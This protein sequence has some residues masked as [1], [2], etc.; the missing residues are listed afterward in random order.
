MLSNK[1]ELCFPSEIFMVKKIIKEIFT[2]LN[3]NIPNIREEDKYDLRLIFSELLC[4]AVIHGNREDSEK[5]V[6]LQVEVDDE[7]VYAI[8]SDEGNGFDP[9]KLLTSFEADSRLEEE[10]GR[11]IKLVYS[12][13]D[14]LA[15]SASGNRIK[16][17]K[18]V[19]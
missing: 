7:R 1:F 11:G 8:I 2:F 13:T 19:G 5:K 16:F 4:N 9:L 6:T 14:Y 15:F 10:N 12:L 3:E 18:R 17:F